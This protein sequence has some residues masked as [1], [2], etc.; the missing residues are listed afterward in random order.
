MDVWDIL[1]DIEDNIGGSVTDEDLREWASRLTEAIYKSEYI[2]QTAGD[3]INT[4]MHECKQAN[5][6]SGCGHSEIHNKILLARYSNL[7]RFV[8]D[9]LNIENREEVFEHCRNVI[10]GTNEQSQP[11]TRPNEAK[12]PQQRTER[13]RLYFDAAI[14]A[15]LMRET[16][17]G[18]K[19]IYQDGSK[20]SLA[21]FLKKIYNPNGL[22]KTP[23]KEMESLF[24]VTRLDRATQQ[25]LDAK[26]TPK[27]REKIDKLF[28]DCIY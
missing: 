21:Y 27:W 14:K 5:F 16:D 24:S 10:N 7:L 17:T 18:Y 1:G 11:G 2:E 28:Q 13:E 4:L 26:N 25:L 3:T 23:Y 20:A 9:S 12:E 8:I 15:G 6:R 19:W 22:G